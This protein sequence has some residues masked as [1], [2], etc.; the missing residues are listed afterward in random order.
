MGDGKRRRRSAGVARL[1]VDGTEVPG[2]M[3][4]ASKL[5]DVGDVVVTMG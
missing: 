5:R 1:V 4:P 3:V 2:K